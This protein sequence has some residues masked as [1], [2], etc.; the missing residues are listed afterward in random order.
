MRIP[1][2]CWY[3]LMMLI[4]GA[5][6]ALAQDKTKNPNAVNDSVV[7]VLRQQLRLAKQDTTRIVVIGKLSVR[8]QQL[9][10]PDS[11]F[12]ILQAGLQLA[13][14]AQSPLNLG[15]IYYQ[16]GHYYDNRFLA[17]QCIDSYQKA[18]P[19]LQ[20][21]GKIAE[22]SDLMY[23]L[24]RVYT[25]RGLVVKAVEQIQK[26]LTYATQTG[27]YRRL[28]S[29][30][31]L[32]YE[33]HTGMNDQKS[34]YNDLLAMLDLARE[35]H[36][37]IDYYLAYEY[38][39]QW[40]EAKQDYARALPYWK[41]GLQ[42]ANQLQRSVLV[43]IMNSCIA[44]NLIKQKRLSEAEPFLIKTFEEAKKDNRI[45]LTYAYKVSARLREQQNR[46]TEAYQ[47][48]QKGIEQEQKNNPSTYLESLEILLDIQEKQ[49]NYQQ[50]LI[51]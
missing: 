43:A 46:L 50:A 19:L 42:V 13:K 24:A 36:N 37:P 18:I 39:A 5:K 34:M 14:K 20:Q 49:G 4:G 30:Y 8:F 44:N 6:T 26:N 1:L 48:I 3:L 16:L 22:A 27:Y 35:H 45:S 2:S 25:G 12:A 17:P 9:G 40:Y 23:T 51:G 38:F 29:A 11:A 32:L 47:L 21:A 15:R 31:A 28:S 10:K 41:R 33:I 7:A